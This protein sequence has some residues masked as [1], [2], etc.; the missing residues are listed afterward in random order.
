MRPQPQDDNNRSGDSQAASHP[1]D[2]LSEPSETAILKT[3][4][5]SALV[6]ALAWRML[7]STRGQAAELV[8]AYSRLRSRVRTHVMPNAVPAATM[9]AMNSM[10]AMNIAR[11]F[12]AAIQ[13]ATLAIRRSGRSGLT[14]MSFGLRCGLLLVV[15]LTIIPAAFV[16]Y[17]VAAIP[18]AGGSSVQ[19]APS[20][21]TFQAGDGRLFATRGIQKGQSISADRIPPLLASAV[22]A[23]EDR[24]FYE[25]GGIDLRAIARAAWHDLTGRRLQ[26]GSTITQQLAR[27]LYLSPERTLKRKIQEAVLAEWL[28]L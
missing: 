20:A 19:V 24:R 2:Q 7:I 14:Q 6:K 4:P 23:V 5:A 28:E 1:S 3:L 18:F 12:Q 9:Q 15:V 17:C 27:R 11:R 25:H 26:G 21:M 13:V 16:A 10:Q 22:I 8:K